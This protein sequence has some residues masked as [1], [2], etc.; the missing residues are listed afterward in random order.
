M[1]P[2]ELDYLAALVRIRTGVE[3]RNQKPHTIVSRL[4]PVAGRFGFRDVRSLIAG[5]PRAPES[6]IGSV[7]DALLVRDTAFFRDAS[8]LDHFR[9][10]VMPELCSL[11]ADARRLR[12]WCA[13]VST[14]QEC[15]SIAILLDE[16]R[17]RERGW[18]I[19]LIG[20]DVSSEAIARAREGIYSRHEIQ[21]GVS[22]DRLLTYFMLEDGQWRVCPRLLGMAR[23]QTVNLLDNF[24]VLGSFDAIFCRNVLIHFDPRTRIDVLA[25]LGNAL[26]PDGRL[27]MG[28]KETAF[29]LGQGLRSRT[30]A[31]IYVKA[32]SRARAFAL[33]S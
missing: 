30:G 32:S 10:E 5:L 25:R 26:A 3:L 23:F 4:D 19:E 21:R 7:V 9:D 17:L 13:G 31:P 1:Q 28:A 11:R 12:I 20:T 18:C 8:T 29:G 6:L 2:G 14:G 24:G 15:L 22:F 33:A 27:I 16:A